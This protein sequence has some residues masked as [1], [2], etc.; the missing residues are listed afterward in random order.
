MFLWFS[1]GEL[2][3]LADLHSVEYWL[4]QRERS[5]IGSRVFHE[6]VKDITMPTW[7]ASSLCLYFVRVG[8]RSTGDHFF[9]DMF[10]ISSWTFAHTLTLSA[11]PNS[12]HDKRKKIKQ[13]RG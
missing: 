3:C 2:R 13:S 10:R 7:T 6:V 11:W 8:K 12:S 5:E 1:E 4:V 9:L